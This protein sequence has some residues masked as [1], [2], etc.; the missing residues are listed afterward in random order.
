[1]TPTYNNNGDNLHSSLLMPSTSDL[2]C[3]LE[4]MGSLPQHSPSDNEPPHLRID[5]TT[6]LNLFKCQ[7]KHLNFFFHNLSLPQTLSFARTLLSASGTIFFT[8]VGKSGFVANK[9]SQTLVSLGIRSAFIS[10]VD[11]LHGDIGILTS[12]DVVV[13]FSKSGTT[14]ELLRL[15]P[16]A[17][18]KGAYLASVTSVEGNALAAACDM[19]VHLPLERELCPFDLAPVTS[20]AIQMVFGDTVAIALMGARNLTKEEY[21]ANHP[22]GRIGK[23]LIFKVKDVMKKQEELPVCREGDLI[24][25]QLVEL[26]SKGCGCLVVIDEEY[27][28]IG[29]FTD[30]DLRRTLKASGEAIFKLTVGEMCNRMPRTISP[31]SMAVEAMK[32]MEAP[33]SPVQFLPVVD[34]R[35]M[36]IGIVTLHGLV[37]AGI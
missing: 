18:A 10:P 34:Y 19:N 16:C 30:G 26:T 23:S 37:S 32:K 20:T 29:T 33:P 25:D 12:C 15:V 5:E 9:I 21:A 28:L 2:A 31:D 8:G 36:L 1:M 35:N 4:T 7:Q 24:M 22:A 27:H 13:L 14:E 17:R 3:P 6:L 11:A